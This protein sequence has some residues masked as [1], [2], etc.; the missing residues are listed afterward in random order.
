MKNL[1]VRTVSGLVLAVVML[2][3]ILYSQWSFGALLLVLLVG[4]MVEF[5]GLARRHGNQPLEVVGIVAGVVLFG[6]SFAITVGGTHSEQLTGIGVV[7]LLLLLLPLMFICELYRRQANPIADIG[8]TLAGLFYVAFPLALMCHIP[9]MWGERQP[10]LMVYY[11]FMIWANDVFAYLVGMAVGRNPLFERLSPKKTWEGFFGGLVGAVLVGVIG[12]WQ[13]GGSP[14][15]WI[16]FA[17]VAAVTGV[18]G[19]LVESM[20]KRA[21]GVK[22]SGS[23]IP[24][25]GGLLDRFDAMLL[26]APFVTVYL[27]YVM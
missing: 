14:A 27:Y 18:L 20:F 12:S 19:D 6:L 15:A 3:C 21:A 16:G 5:Y 2:V 4:G 8:A 7:F 22:D 11:L 1:V 24:G 26:S 13:V 9:T 17:L 25:H 10:V 23:I